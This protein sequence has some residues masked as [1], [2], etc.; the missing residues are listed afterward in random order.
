MPARNQP[1]SVLQLYSVYH[2]HVALLTVLEVL[3]AYNSIIRV[4]L[5][6]HDEPL[7]MLIDD[8]NI[9]YNGREYTDFSV[10]SIALTRKQW[11]EL[12]VNLHPFNY[13]QTMEG[14]SKLLLESRADAL[15]NRGE[16]RPIISETLAADLFD[17]APIPP[18]LSRIVEEG[19]LEYDPSQAPSSAWNADPFAHA[20][21]GAL[22]RNQPD[23]THIPLDRNLGDE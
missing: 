19:E 7:F 8:N 1:L 22:G 20:F 5:P 11:P 2:D 16:R 3:A 10:A 4:R 23:F 12:M 13:N 14:Q 18:M 21:R 6:G 15:Q 17:R 9:Q